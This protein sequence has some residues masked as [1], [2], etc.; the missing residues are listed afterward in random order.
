MPGLTDCA[1]IHPPRRKTPIARMQL[2][3]CNNP[4][5][6]SLPLEASIC[7]GETRSPSIAVI[8]FALLLLESTAICLD[9]SPR[10]RLRGAGFRQ[11]RELTRYS[12]PWRAALQFVDSA[13]W[14]PPVMGRSSD[15]AKSIAGRLAA[16]SEKSAR[17]FRGKRTFGRFITLMPGLC[18]GV[19]AFRETIASRARI[20]GGWSPE[21]PNAK[22]L[23]ALRIAD[24]GPEAC[25]KS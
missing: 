5:L 23:A 21:R 8:P 12:M 18:R 20:V 6:V 25:G 11:R 13:T 10:L 17:N 15:R 19:V 1:T 22:H 7:I 4:R 9:C 3:R 14:L 2:A 16:S 24:L